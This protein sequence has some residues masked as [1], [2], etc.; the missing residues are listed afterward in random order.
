MSRTSLRRLR[1]Q[2]F[3][4]E[5]EADHA[6]AG[7]DAAVDVRIN[8][9]HDRLPDSA[10]NV[11]F[12]E[13]S[14]SASEEQENIVSTSESESLLSNSHGSHSEP[15]DSEDNVDSN[16]STHSSNSNQSSDTDELSEKQ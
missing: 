14:L 4:H 7:G 8:D 15:S 6:D 2:L 3:T 10:A 13:L 16:C 1:L 5:N 12:H 11:H 9:S